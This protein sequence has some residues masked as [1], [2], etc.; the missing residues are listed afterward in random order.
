[1]TKNNFNIE[2]IK[3]RVPFVV[4]FFYVVNYSNK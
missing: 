3:T 1:M 2:F 4:E